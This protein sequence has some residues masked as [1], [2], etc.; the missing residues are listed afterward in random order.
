MQVGWECD[1]AATFSGLR[2]YAWIP[3]PQQATGD[4]RVDDS[5]ANR[6]VR[7]AIDRQLATQGFVA[8]APE[9]A[10]FWVGYHVR[11][12]DKIHTTTT[13]TY[14][15]YNR[16]WG[17]DAGLDLG[18]NLG[19]APTVYSHRYDIGTLTV[20]VE[21]PATQRPIWQGFARAEIEPS[22]DIETRDQRLTKAAA[23]ILEQFPR[24][25]SPASSG[26]Q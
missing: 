25:A 13:G 4:P 17:G 26:A 8:A 22:D 5:T 6:R 3:G 24:P 16:S 19:G 18:W 20:F 11:L 15:G 12:L 10:D 2:T 21:A 14:Y 1:P 9:Q 23:G 7:Q